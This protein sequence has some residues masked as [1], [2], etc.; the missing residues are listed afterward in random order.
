MFS[1]EQETG[2]KTL[3]LLHC[4][5]SF[6]RRK[7]DLSGSCSEIVVTGLLSQLE[8]FWGQTLQWPF[9]KKVVNVQEDKNEL[10]LNLWL[11]ARAFLGI[12]VIFHVL[13]QRDSGGENMIWVE[14]VVS[15][16]KTLSGKWLLF[17]P[18]WVQ[19]HLGVPYFPLFW[20]GRRMFKHYKP[21]NN[22][23]VNNPSGQKIIWMNLRNFRSTS[24]FLFGLFA[25]LVDSSIHM[26]AVWWTATQLMLSEQMSESSQC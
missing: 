14:L 19:K 16:T 13:S 6:W 8:S 26:F 10:V 24:T 2:G 17:F 9:N 12:S 23:Q 20:I 4:S 3:F 15:K 1:S 18:M 21:R 25:C 7:R 5:E 22:V 11:P